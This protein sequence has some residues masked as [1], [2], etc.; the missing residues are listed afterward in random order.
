MV[1]RY[2]QRTGAITKLDMAAYETGDNF[3]FKSHHNGKD[4]WQWLDENPEE[5]I[6]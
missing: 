1:L 4:F 5:R 3:P 2:G 6:L